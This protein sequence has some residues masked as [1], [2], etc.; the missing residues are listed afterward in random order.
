LTAFDQGL[1]EAAK[2]SHH[3]KALDHA[4]W[5]GLVR[6]LTEAAEWQ[7]Q[8]LNDVMCAL[9][10]MG[11]EDATILAGV[12]H[13][14]QRRL[15]RDERWGAVLQEKVGMAKGYWDQ[16]TEWT[17]LF[18]SIKTRAAAKLACPPLM[19]TTNYDDLVA[20][21]CGLKVLSV[22][23]EPGPRRRLTLDDPEDHETTEKD[24][25]RV[26]QYEAPA[27]LAE[28]HEAKAYW[29]LYEQGLLEPEEYFVHHLHGW[30]RRPDSIILDAA[31]YASRL[32]ESPDE[33]LSLWLRTESKVVVI[34]G[35]GAGLFDDHLGRVLLEA[36]L[37]L[38]HDPAAGPPLHNYWIELARE[39]EESLYK[40]QAKFEE[41]V[42]KVATV[43]LR[44]AAEAGPGP[45]DEAAIRDAAAAQKRAAAGLITAVFV[46]TFDE[47]PQ[48]IGQL[49]HG[50]SGALLPASNP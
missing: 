19:V 22:D 49:L 15:R 2:V 24:P 35:M 43:R 17:V 12:A 9:A 26:R 39:W 7:P 31:D 40:V 14:V 21:A 37:T 36:A 25:A 4:T 30:W 11:R 42:E 44:K 50:G 16:K 29:S 47:M 32:D 1:L 8:S 33:G 28:F 3:R 46:K 20:R 27:H 10:V 6:S 18:E 48:A 38:A 23:A 45:V 5:D 41:E 13:P 34:A